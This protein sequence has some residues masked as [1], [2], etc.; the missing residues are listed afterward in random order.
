MAKARSPFP[1]TPEATV[2]EVA[3]RL[4]QVAVKL[5]LRHFEVLNIL[6]DAIIA[7]ADF[8]VAKAMELNSSTMAASEPLGEALAMLVLET[9]RGYLTPYSSMP[10]S[11]ILRRSQSS[12]TC[13]LSACACR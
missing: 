11:L 13:R 7:L 10:I 8:D 9:E 1:A 3:R 5:H 2:L 6:L 4:E 12:S